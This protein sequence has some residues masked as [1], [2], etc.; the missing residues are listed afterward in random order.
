MMK[1][2]SVKFLPLFFAGFVC[3][4]LAQDR[5]CAGQQT[6]LYAEEETSPSSETLNRPGDFISVFGSNC[7]TEETSSF[8]R[9][10]EYDV[11]E[12]VERRLKS[13]CEDEGR[14][15]EPA[16]AGRAGQEIEGL[17]SLREEQKYQAAEG[18][19]SDVADLV[20]EIKDADLIRAVSVFAIP[21]TDFHIGLACEALDLSKI[22][23]R[24][25]L[26]DE[27]DGQFDRQR[28]TE[29]ERRNSRRSRA[30]AEFEDFIERGGSFDELDGFIE[31]IGPFDESMTPAQRSACVTYYFFGAI[32]KNAE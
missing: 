20:K 21:M 24:K 30:V 6:C 18:A 3:S 11:V 1:R 19:Y 26:I 5:D 2:L 12:T 10:F 31:R 23:K 13:V 4:A 25:G 9:E 17:R 7:L 16:Q 32:E 28:R 27:F 29:L 22:Q 14:Q 8:L 15:V